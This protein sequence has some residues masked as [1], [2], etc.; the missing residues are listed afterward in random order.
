MKPPKFTSGNKAF[1]KALNEVVEYARKNGVNPAG[2]PGWSQSP[3]GWVPPLRGGAG[4]SGRAGFEVYSGS[5]GETRGV[6]VMPSVIFGAGASAAMPEYN[7][8]PLDDEDPP[9]I[10]LPDEENRVIGLLIELVPDVEQ[11]ELY[12]LAEG[13][14]AP[15]PYWRIL[16]GGGILEG[17]VEVKSYADFDE[18]AEEAQLPE[19]DSSSGAVNQNGK[20]VIPLAKRYSDGR[21]IQIGYFG[22]IGIRMCASGALVVLGQAQVKCE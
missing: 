6:R 12:A 8:T 17:I 1:Q 15:D 11:V 14:T 5:D 2:R 10:P 4:C 19:I 20:Y 16:E 21:L 3:D 9:L 22:P 18:M 7:G 13:E